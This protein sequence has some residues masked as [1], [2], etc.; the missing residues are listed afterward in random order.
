MN[1]ITELSFGD[2]LDKT[3]RLY[4]ANFW[5]LLAISAVMLL[6]SFL[7]TM[8]NSRSVSVEPGEIEGQLLN[9]LQTL[10]TALIFGL[11]MVFVYGAL[12]EA[13][14]AAYL[15]GKIE[16]NDAFKAAKSRYFAMMGT[17]LLLG[18]AVSLSML[19][20]IIPGVYLAVCFS[21][22]AQIVVLEHLSGT[23]A[24]SRSYSL[25]KGAW[26]RVATVGFVIG[27]LAMVIQFALSIP[28]GI[29]A[30]FATF[31]PAY[32]EPL[33]LISQALQSIVSVVV[34]PLSMIGTTVLYFD[35]RVRKEGFD[36]WLSA[37]EINEPE[38]VA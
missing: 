13:I 2:L 8:T 38:P 28:V 19:F 25:V 32:A 18:I 1:K 24:L 12:V 23:K 4:S 11:V 5:P 10:S 20:F 22:V 26:W 14:S 9:A 15:D 37:D 6:P 16:L 34:T 29:L 3:V 30:G 31:M 36:L 35:Q 27:L 17:S 7:F 33:T 21:F